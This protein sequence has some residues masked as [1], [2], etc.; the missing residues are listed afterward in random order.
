[1]DRVKLGVDE[2]TGESVA[3]KIM[4]KENMSTRAKQQL[5]R[6]ITSM[7]ALNH[8]HVLRLRDV[9]EVRIPLIFTE[10]Y[11]GIPVLVLTRLYIVYWHH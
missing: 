11:T 2:R 10:R 3:V 1:M 4:Y 9:H 7:K 6:E 5:R 8:P